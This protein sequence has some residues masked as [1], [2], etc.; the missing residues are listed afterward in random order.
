MDPLPPPRRFLR[1][2]GFKCA[3]KS[4]FWSM[5]IGFLSVSINYLVYR[6]SKWQQIEWYWN[7]C[8]K[9]IHPS[10]KYFLGRSKLF[11]L[12]ECYDDRL[13]FRC[14]FIPINTLTGGLMD[15]YST[16]IL[17]ELGHIFNLQTELV[18]MAMSLIKNFNAW[19]FIWQIFLA[20]ICSTQVAYH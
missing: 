15:I 17:C 11:W 12:I 10:S 16:S 19:F 3:T 18:N 9:I 7:N 14:W 1:R 4:K 2:H 20:Q 5:K 6:N 8:H 13:I